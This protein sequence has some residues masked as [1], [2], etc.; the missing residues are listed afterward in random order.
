MSLL[1]A[2]QGAP[3][4][5]L[6]RDEEIPVENAAAPLVT[7][8]LDCSIPVEAG[9]L[10]AIG[11][12]IPVEGGDLVVVT[13][14]IPVESLASQALNG[15]I[16]V[17]AG[18]GVSP[19]GTIPIDSLAGKTVEQTIP[20][21]AGL[22]VSKVETPP[23]TDAVYDSGVYDPGVYL[24]AS[25]RQ[26]EDR[27]IPIDTGI[28]LARTE[29]IPVEHGEGAP[30]SLYPFRTS[31]EYGY[32][33]PYGNIEYGAAEFPLVRDE[34]I[35]IDTEPSRAL[36]RDESIP[37]EAGGLLVRDEEILVEQFPVVFNIVRDEEIPVE[38]PAPPQPGQ[39]RTVTQFIAWFQGSA[40][41]QVDQGGDFAKYFQGSPVLTLEAKVLIE[42]GEQIPIDN[43]VSVARTEEIPVESGDL[44]IRD[45]DIPVEYG[46]QATTLTRDEEIP[47]ET[48]AALVRDEEIPIDSTGVVLTTLVRD[49]E[50]PVESL[51]QT[52]PFTFMDFLAGA[53][54]PWPP[55]WLTRPKLLADERH[56]GSI[57]FYGRSRQV[58]RR[59]RAPLPIVIGKPIRRRPVHRPAIVQATLVTRQLSEALCFVGGKST[60]K[61][62]H[63]WKMI[64]EADE[65]E[66]MTIIQVL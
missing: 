41:M 46:S 54:A 42:L 58:V 17:E 6:T 13:G 19:D 5:T 52:L 7:L 57:R 8:T 29:E 11:V 22:I 33:L 27:E 36:N 60:Q 35:P 45:E 31:A 37:V 55:S 32:N 21:D 39:R 65:R 14:A 1:L 9:V 43:V 10:L 53:G 47:I 15:T 49:E 3:Q 12:S 34:E 59:P 30:S 25:S 56:C 40:V 51:A 48:L 4:Q 50:I 26:G 28:A 2:A 44:L 18:A 24:A 66:I 16:P 63:D 38:V 20:I 23:P 64:R 61:I 62:G